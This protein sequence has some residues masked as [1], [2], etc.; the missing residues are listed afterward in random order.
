MKKIALF[1]TSVLITLCATSQSRVLDSLKTSALHASQDSMLANNWTSTADEYIKYNLDSALRFAQKSY[2]LSST[3][4]YSVGVADA[5]AMQAKVFLTKGAY[6][7]AYELYL[8]ALHKF[9]MLNHPAGIA[10]VD[11]GLGQTFQKQGNYTRA[12]QYFQRALTIQQ[13]LKTKS[14][15]ALTYLNMGIINSETNQLAKAEGF[16]LKASHL[17]EAEGDKLMSIAIHMHMGTLYADLHENKKA[18][19][20][21]VRA[22]NLSLIAGQLTSVAEAYLNMGNTYRKIG[23][24]DSASVSFNNALIYFTQLQD[25]NNMARVYSGVATLLVQQKNFERALQY[26]NKSNEIARELSDKSILYVNYKLLVDVSKATMNY[27]QAYAYYDK[28]L[29]LKDSLF[30]AEKL[31]SI[32]NVKA[33]YDLEQKQKTIEELKEDNEVKTRQRNYLIL[34]VSLVVLSLILL[35]YSAS[36]IKDKTKLLQHQK[37]LVEEQ[38]DELETQKNELED[39]NLVKDKFFSVLSHDLRS[40]MGNILGLLNL[41][42][43][44]GIIGEHE[45]QQ[46]FNRLKLSTSSALETMDNMLAWGKNQIKE[47]KMQIKEVNVY[48][49]A[50]R[51]CRF[52]NQSAENKSIQIVNQINPSVK[53][54]ADKNRLEFVI[55]NLI[56]NALKFSHKNSR[57]ELWTSADDDF[58]N[59]HV[60]DFGTGMKRELQEKLF[61]VNKRESVNGTAGETGSGL[62]L[63]LSKEFITQ[64]NGDILVNSEPG[65]G[66]IFTI[67]HRYN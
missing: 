51:V 26:I 15:L 11:N 67:Q 47:N 58:V 50:E 16:Y 21:L 42:S 52:L 39:L 24:Y 14:G 41:I 27:K 40:P 17:A 59:I 48:E 66:T 32:E 65:M 61:D 28:V 8:E 1:A 63:A 3:I 57:I 36:Q 29:R 62:G 25:A 44:E 6:A 34:L 54:M 60:K 4:K 5:L 10:K 45:K 53:I 37:Q 20:A 30:N 18:L 23:Q 33:F 31:S 19:H 46:L 2:K 7:K 35:A 12:L 22:K 38:K 9:T 55:R 56:S 49:V 13:S 64:N 43:Q